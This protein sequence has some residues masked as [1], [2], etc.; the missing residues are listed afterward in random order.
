M[1]TQYDT[2][3]GSK[4][5]EEVQ[6]E[7]Q[8]SRAEVEQTLD[9][10]Q[11]RLSPGQM[12]EQFIDYMRSSNGNEFMRNLGTR[13]RDNPLPVALVGAG[14]AWLMMSG[15]RS[16]RRRYAD[17]DM[18]DE[19]PEERYGVGEYG[20]DYH[21]AAEYPGEYA[22]EAPFGEPLGEA[23]RKGGRSYAEWAKRSAEAA[24]R[25]AGQMHVGGGTRGYRPSEEGGSSE[26]WTGGAR[27]AA[28]RWTQ[29]AREAIGQ[30]REGSGR[31]SSGGGWRVRERAREFGSSARQRF[32][33]TGEHLWEGARGA[34]ERGGYYG[35][36]VRRGFMDTLQEQPLVL[37]ALGL[38][39]GAAIGAAL[40]RTEREDE[41]MGDARDQLKDRARRMTHEQLD[42]ARAAGRAAYEAAIEEAD[43]Q[44]WSAEGAMSAVDSAAQKAERVAEAATEAAKAEANRPGGPSGSSTAGSSTGTGTPP[45]GSGQAPAGA[46]TARTEAERHGVGGTSS[47][48]PTG[49]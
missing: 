8:Q 22:H 10:I 49:T 4:S 37:A 29:G 47:R 48:I 18:F 15:A 39:V 27:E 35:E 33:E 11:E 19:Y 17:E 16:E 41:W 21:G 1:S 30:W 13:I 20:G 23:A 46:S 7:V 5:P 31:E 45:S 43:R 9:A 24:R 42:R 12:F 36:R 34:R 44:G 28:S 6:R 3:P 25:R 26:G 40:P 2:N 32:A 38:A 14:L